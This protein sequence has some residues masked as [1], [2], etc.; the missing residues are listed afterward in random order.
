MLLNLNGFLRFVSVCLSV[1][2]CVCVRACVCV[3]ERETERETET[4]REREVSDTG[5][6]G[7]FYDHIQWLNQ[8]TRISL[9]PKQFPRIASQDTISQRLGCVCDL[10][11]DLNLGDRLSP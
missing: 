10:N 2:L 6:S 11:R 3:C 1:C 5:Q 9:P 4:E 7:V 8:E